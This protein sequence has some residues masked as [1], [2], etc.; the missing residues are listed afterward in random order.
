MKGE[1]I[2]RLEKMHS[3][4]DQIKNTL[5][6]IHGEMTDEYEKKSEKWQDG[7]T[8]KEMEEKIE[9]LNDALS[10]LEDAMSAIEQAKGG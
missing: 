3:D 8:G 7:E 2:K 1:H 4:L 10:E 6:A 5:Q 9:H